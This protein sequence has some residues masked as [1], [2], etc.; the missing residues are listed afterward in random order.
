MARELTKKQKD[1]CDE[2]LKDGNRSKAAEKVYNVKNKNVARNIGSEN[3][4]KPNIREYLKGHAQSASETIID[5]MN[6]SQDD[7]NRIVCAKDVLDRSG[8]KPTEKHEIEVKRIDGFKYLEPDKI[9]DK[10]K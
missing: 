6:N 5:I 7:R 4:S 8:N 1:F 2:Y 9:V 10:P 3:L